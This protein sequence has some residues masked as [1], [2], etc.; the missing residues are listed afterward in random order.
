MKKE[1]YRHGVI[2]SITI[3]WQRTRVPNTKEILH[4]NIKEHG[5]KCIKKWCSQSQKIFYQPKYNTLNS[6]QYEPILLYWC[7]TWELVLSTGYRPLDRTETQLYPPMCVITAEHTSILVPI[8][9][10]PLRQ[11]RSLQRENCQGT[12][13]RSVNR[14]PK[15]IKWLHI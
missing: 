11:D 10:R 8:L 3:I 13:E 2:N 15:G 9:H 12:A 6:K 14:Y 1:S 4:I 7:W 5:I